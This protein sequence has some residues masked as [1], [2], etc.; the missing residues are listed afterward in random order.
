M[1]EKPVPV[2]GGERGRVGERGRGATA[3]PGLA[4][5][6]PKASSGQFLLEVG[7]KAGLVKPIPAL[8][9]CRDPPATPT[10]T[11]TPFPHPSM[12]DLEPLGSPSPQQRFH[13]TVCSTWC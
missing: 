9:L 2:P 12:E 13:N 4:A 3:D 6:T 7:L 1:L 8:S 10:M 5:P 11:D